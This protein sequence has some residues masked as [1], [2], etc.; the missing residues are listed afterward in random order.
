MNRQAFSVSIRS[1]VAVVALCFAGLAHAQSGGQASTPAGQSARETEAFEEII[2]TARRTEENLQS[3]PVTV[4]AL[5]GKALQAQ[6]IKSAYDLQFAAPSVTVSTGLS[7][8]SGGYSVRGLRAGVVTY[9][10]D[11]PGGPVLTSTPYFDLASVQVLNGPQGTLFGRTAAAG[12]VLVTPASPDLTNFG[13]FADVTAGNYGR[14]QTSGAVNLPIISGEL[15]LRLAYQHREIDGYTRQIGTDRRYDAVND[16]AFR[17]TLKWQRG[18][19]TNTLIGNFLDVDNSGPGWVLAGANPNLSTLNIPPAA[20]SLFFG[21]A[22]NGAVA[23]GLESSF[24]GCV[25][26]RLA[27]TQQ[28]R[29]DLIAEANRVQNGGSS[30]VRSTLAPYAFPDQQR[31][32]HTSVMDIAQYDIGDLGPTT[33]TLKNLFSYQRNSTVAAYGLDGFGGRLLTVVGSTA[34]GASSVN[35]VGNMVDPRRGKPDRLITEEFQLKGKAAD[36][37]DW[38]LGIYYQ[39]SKTLEDLDGVQAMTQTFS[40]IFTPNRGF[41]GAYN[42]QAGSDSRELAGFGQV[43]LDFGKI[44]IPGLSVTAGYRYTDAETNAR[45]IRALTN[46]SGTGPLIPSTLASDF[47]TTT[48]KSH[49]SNYSFSI[50]QQ[51]TPEILAYASTAKSFVPGGVNAVAGCNTVPNCSPTYDPEQVKNYEIGLKTQ[52][53]LGSARVT[54]NTDIYR[55]DYSNIQQGNQVTSQSSSIAFIANVAAARMQGVETHLNIAWK[56]GLNLTLNYS[57]LDAKYRNWVAIDPNNIRLPSDQCIPQSVP[58]SLCYIDLSNNPFP[59]APKHQLNAT[60]R[61]ELPVPEEFG[62]PWISVTGYLQSRQYLPTLPSFRILQIAEAQGIAGITRDTVSQQ[63]YSKV[64]LRVQWDE[65]MGSRFSAGLFVD[66][67]T[68][69]TYSQGGGANLF[70][71]GTAFKLYSEPRMWGLNLSYRFGG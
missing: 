31:Y 4:T 32:R 68:N 11:I 66:N 35:Q 45:T 63:S 24:A 8:L 56:E 54:F 61:Y 27:V 62:K 39:N 26:S 17:A 22:C 64:N 34:T 19:F 14:F 1:S 52:F 25:A 47:A 49:G 46:P 41:T 42:F 6:G 15:G 16:D 38:T 33:L 18:S 50:T 7:R 10:D 70:T 5:S 30:A 21:G 57:Y 53:P 40:G 28:L 67:L 48:S 37:A 60:L 13:G 2:V 3:V 29:A 69:T 44:G 55:M 9:F 71:L 43:S 20:A 59:Q 58:S 65:L 36:F 51:I 12:A 23:S